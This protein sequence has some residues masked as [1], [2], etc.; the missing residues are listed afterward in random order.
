MLEKARA[1]GPLLS[2]EGGNSL[3]PKVVSPPSE[4]EVQQ[5]RIKAQLIAESLVAD[6]TDAMALGASDWALGTSF[7]RDLVEKNHLPVLAANLECDGSHPYPASRVLESGGHKIGVIGLTT[8]EV[9]GCV[10]GD[11]RE[12]AKAAVAELGKVDVVLALVPVSTERDVRM[13]AAPSEQA[14]ALGIDVVIDSRGRPASA[15]VDEHNRSWFVGA[16]ER[17]KWVAFVDLKFARGASRWMAVGGTE[18]EEVRLS[19]LKERYDAMDARIASAS[20]PELQA[21]LTAQK[22]R[23]QKEIAELEQQL[24]SPPDLSHANTIE[25]HSVELGADVPDQPAAAARVK[26]AKEAVVAASGQDPGQFVPRLVA[27]TSSAYAGGEACV[28][29]H[30]KEHAQWSTTPHARAFQS[31][32]QVNR[33]LDAQCFSCHVT[34]ANKGGPDEP[35]STAGYR[36]VQCEACH[37]PAR[38]HAADP[39]NVRTQF[40]KPVPVHCTACHDGEQDQGRFDADKYFPQILHDAVPATP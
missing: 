40:A 20:S 7:V 9:E 27:D 11:L 12:A 29:C 6:G 18:K 23:Y 14:E 26:A 19:S 15:G 28:A 2:L 36:D 30:Q 31:L 32:V 24:A 5:R 33:A 4:V 38:G 37:G 39:E 22:G 3:G 17:Q 35:L 34:G 16:G 13:F 1:A 25:L 8:G 21:R 10:V